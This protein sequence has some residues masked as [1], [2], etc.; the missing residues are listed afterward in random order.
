MPLNVGGTAALRVGV[1]P[2]SW[3]NLHAVVALGYVRE[4]WNPPVYNDDIA[5]AAWIPGTVGGTNGGYFQVAMSG[6]I[7]RFRMNGMFHGQHTFAD[8]RDPLD[9]TVDLNASYR[10]A[11]HFRAGLEYVGQDLEETFSPG[12]EGGPRHFMGPVA[13][14]QLWN[15]RVTV[16]GGPAVGLSALSPDFV[17]RVAASVGF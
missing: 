6:D 17:A 9:I 12:A 15:E 16:I 1:L 4:A 2:S 11:G 10:I 3:K 5:P 8:G 7:G 14:I 13:S